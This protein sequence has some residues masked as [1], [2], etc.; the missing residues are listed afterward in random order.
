MTC[1]RI[2]A[3]C[4]ADSTEGT[5]DVEAF[6]FLTVGCEISGVDGDD[7]AIAI[8]KS[9]SFC[10]DVIEADTRT[11]IVRLELVNICD[12]FITTL[13]TGADFFVLFP[14]LEPLDAM[15]RIIWCCLRNIWQFLSIMMTADVLRAHY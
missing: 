4:F 1:T 14:A 6:G 11:G 10:F 15:L 3:Q 8:R 5:T 13:G 9:D 12:Q 7:G 2:D